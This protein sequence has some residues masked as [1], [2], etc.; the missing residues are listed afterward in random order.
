MVSGRGAPRERQALV[1]REGTPNVSAL[2]RAARR[3]AVRSRRTHALLPS[4]L[5][6]RR[7]DAGAVIG[8][9]LEQAAAGSG[10]RPIA[11]RLAL[12]HPTVRDWWRRVRTRAPTLLASLLAIATS[13]DAA[14]VDLRRD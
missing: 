12:P 1:S 9:A 8:S 2:E 4:F 5:F 3:G 13:L 6:I 11:Q 10:A 7:L 14:P